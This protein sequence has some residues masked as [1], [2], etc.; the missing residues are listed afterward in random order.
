MPLRPGTLVVFEGLDKTGKTTQRDA[1]QAA[2]WDP[3]GPLVTH[4]GGARR[5]TLG[6]TRCR[7][8][9]P[10]HSA[11]RVQLG[12]YLARDSPGFPATQIADDPSRPLRSY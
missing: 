11:V 12:P 1:L 10:R 7:A 3:P 2:A 9:P 6:S 8:P 5:Q 4:R